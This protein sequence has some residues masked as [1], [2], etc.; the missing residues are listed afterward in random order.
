MD[1]DVDL[2]PTDAS[3][4]L[5]AQGA[6]QDET[7][8]MKRRR[9]AASPIRALLAAGCGATLLYCATPCAN[10]Q[11]FELTSSDMKPSEPMPN[12]HVFTGMGCKGENLS[13]ALSWSG[14]PEGTKSFA[15]MVHDPDAN[16]GGAGIWH[17]VVVNIPATVSSLE[18]GTS[19]A[20]GAKMP[21]GSRQIANDYIGMTGSPAWGG[22]CPPKGQKAHSYNFTIYALKVE[23]LDLPPAATASQAGFFVNLN[24]LDKARLTI[25]YGR[26]E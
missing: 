23:K 2:E 17:W 19:T 9:I 4:R 6:K 26:Q 1:I 16:T 25:T 15:L 24:A 13:P 3:R 5:F 14:A 21:P 11:A 12:R 7:I 10:A 20:D 22:P 18:A 8:P